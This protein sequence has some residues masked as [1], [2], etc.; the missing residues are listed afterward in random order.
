M[1]KATCWFFPIIAIGFIIAYILIVA[2]I[3]PLTGFESILFQVII[4]L[5]S[6]VASYIF[7]F[8]SAKSAAKELIKPYARSAFRRLLSLSNGLLRL[9]ATIQ[10]TR[11]VSESGTIPT[12]A[13]DKLEVMATDLIYTS[14]DALEDWH[15]IVP[16]D[17]K[18]LW[19][20]IENGQKMENMK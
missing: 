9:A 17:L 14:G 11:L 16:E 19:D 7:G 2:V 5:I 8:K 4:L 6:I 3:R 13:L 18:D 1:N 15:D 10:K 20:R 12:Y